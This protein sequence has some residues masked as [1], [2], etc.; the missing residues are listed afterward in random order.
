MNVRS[1]PAVCSLIGLALGLVFTAPA[2]AQSR[3]GDRTVGGGVSGVNRDSGLTQTGQISSSAAIQRDAG[4]FIGSGAGGNIRSNV[5]LPIGG[6]LGLGPNLG[7][8]LKFGSSILGGPGSFGGFGGGG[9]NSAQF[10]R[11][12]QQ[13][14]QNAFGQGN[15]SQNPL[16]A[17]IRIGF[18]QAPTPGSVV[19]QRF[20]R[21]LDNL[22]GIQLR[23]KVTV[24]M[25]GRT[26]VLRGIVTSENDRDLVGRLAQLEPGISEVRNEL[27]IAETVA[28]R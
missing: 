6:A 9:L 28:P 13:N 1:L 12:G 17:P 2:A 19:S 26:A 22:P 21:R 20:S 24:E 15:Q 11:G 7:A 14:G 3:F 4:S 18:T 27:T 8:G 25:D 23:S 5:D 16:R 10:G